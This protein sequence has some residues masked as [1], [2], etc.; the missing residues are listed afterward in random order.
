MEFFKRRRNFMQDMFDFLN[1]TILE[2]YIQ[3]KRD[4]P[5]RRD[6]NAYHIWISEI[7][8]QQTRVEAVIPYYERF[9]KRIPDVCS[10]AKVPSDELLKLWQGLGYYS[11]AR[12]LQKAAQ[13]LAQDGKTEL[14]LTYHELLKLPGIGTYTAGAIASIAYQ[15]VVPAVD[16][17]VLRV[18]T[19]YLGQ[20]DNISDAKT[21]KKYEQLLL[22]HM[23]KKHPGDFNQALMEL[24]ATICIPNGNP[25]CN[26]CPLQEKCQAYQKGLLAILPIRNAKVKKRLEER[27]VLIFTYKDQVVIQKRP[28]TGLLASLFEFPNIESHYTIEQV[29][30]YLKEQNILYQ[31]IQNGP[32]ARHIFTHL[33]WNMI[34]YK[35]DLSYPCKKKQWIWATREQLKQN[36][37]IPTAFSKFLLE[38]LN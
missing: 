2:W 31:R 4:L 38:V 18:M 35:I 24:G 32:P 12:N 5:W 27:T 33:Q 14:P 11:R 26:I 16:G 8:L 19:R 6:Q 28:T 25:R 10:L 22:K 1:P 3:N 34:S 30:Q 17:N 20:K 13:I 29:K 7:M 21:K 9:L 23:S 36:Y 37:S 15:E